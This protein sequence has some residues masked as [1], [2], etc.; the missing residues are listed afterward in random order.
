MNKEKRSRYNKEYKDTN[1]NEL[2]KYQREYND[3]NKDK[4]KKQQKQ[5]YHANEDKIKEQQKQYCAVHR[6]ELAQ[7]KRIENW[8]QQGL[9]ID[10]AIKT[11]NEIDKCMICGTSKNLCLDHD[12]STKEIRGVLC[13][14]CNLGIG[15]FRDDITL[16]A[17]AIEYL[18]RE[19]NGCA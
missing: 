15:H 8:R 19:I 18:T 3:I 13:S 7:K 14:N 6:D 9:D 4:I 17:K 10:I 2:R 11:I 12:H 1:I 5:Y 16:L